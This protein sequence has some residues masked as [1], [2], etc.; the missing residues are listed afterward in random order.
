MFQPIYEF[1]YMMRQSIL[2]SNCIIIF[3]LILIF[4][5]RSGEECVQNN[6]SIISGRTSSDNNVNSNNN[7][8]SATVNNNSTNLIDRIKEDERREEAGTG[9][10]DSPDRAALDDS[11][12]SDRDSASQIGKG[13][14]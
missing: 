11:D 4:H 1:N 5:F 14:N 12:L 9:S 13:I 6:N 7:N 8:N 3:S 2:I 10:I